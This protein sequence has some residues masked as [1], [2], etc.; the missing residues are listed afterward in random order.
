MNR[1]P[2]KFKSKLLL[3]VF[4]RG[5]YKP[6]EPVVTRPRRLRQVTKALAMF[7]SWVRVLRELRSASESLGAGLRGYVTPEQEAFIG[8]LTPS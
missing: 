4:V 5:I 2:G 3:V 8:F 6:S 1:D 7:Q